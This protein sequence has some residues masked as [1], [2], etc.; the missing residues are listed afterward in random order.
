MDTLVACPNVVNHEN[1]HEDNDY[2]NEGDVILGNRGG[3]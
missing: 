2:E 3:D 1:D